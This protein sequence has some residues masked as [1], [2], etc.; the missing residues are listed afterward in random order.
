MTISVGDKLPEA[1]FYV[2]GE[3]GPEKRTTADVFDG[4]CVALFAVPGAFTPTCS[5]NHLPGF[6]ANLEMFKEK[7]VDEVVCVAVNDPFVLAAWA[8][9]TGAKGRITFLADGNGDFTRAIGME[10]DA[11]ARGLGKRSQRYAMLVDDREV[12][13]FN[14]EDAPGKAEASSAES[15]LKV[16]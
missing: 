14:A 11:S 6:L 15:L 5:M 3:N 9:K 7:G 2:L 8:E 10:L 13:A 1:N 12:K 16:L 4:R